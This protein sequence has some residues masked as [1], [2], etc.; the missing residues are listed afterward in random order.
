MDSWPVFLLRI[1]SL[2]QS[3]ASCRQKFSLALSVEMSVREY[4]SDSSNEIR[5]PKKRRNVDIFL[6]SEEEEETVGEWHD[7]RG[8]QPKIV[9]FTHPSG[10]VSENLHVE[11]DISVETS[12]LLFVPDEL[13]L[14][15]SEQTNL[16]AA[17]KLESGHA[18]RLTKWTETNKS[19]I[20]RFF[21]LILWMGLVKLPAIHQYWSNDPAYMQTFPK[22]VMSRNRFELLLRMLHF[23]DNQNSNGSNRLFKIQPIIN[24]LETN[25]QKYYNP[26]EDIWKNLER[27]NTTPTNIVMSLCRDLFHKGHTLYTDNWYTSL[28][29]AEK[30]IHKNTHLVGTLR[31]NRRGNSQQV[32]STKLKRGEIVAKENNQGI[33]ILKWRDKKDILVLSTRHSSEMV[34]VQCRSGNKFKPQ[35]IVDYNREKA[36]VDLSD[37]MNSYNNPLRRSTKC[38]LF[39]AA[40]VKGQCHPA[41]AD[42]A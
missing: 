41:V 35:I 4:E 27:E 21:G 22:K 7:P 13:F 32:I 30:L 12:Y 36:A 16:Y 14:K 17:Q 15:I 19:E 38:Q 11:S 25:Y 31:S 26:S 24:T 6:S 2:L 40:Y 28:E 23:V 5:F 20:K 39:F 29:L 10:F 9:P 42:T 34:N 3:L 33:T 37:Q 8:N 18:H 1:S